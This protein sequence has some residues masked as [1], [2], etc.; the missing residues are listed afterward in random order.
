MKICNHFIRRNT[1]HDAIYSAMFQ[2]LLIHSLT[3]GQR[4]YIENE[5]EKNHK[6]IFSVLKAKRFMTWTV[7][8]GIP[9][10]LKIRVT[11]TTM[12]C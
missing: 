8:K 6:N 7:L 9:S 3:Y 11:K 4:K 12:F 10:E 1:H 2:P 5:E